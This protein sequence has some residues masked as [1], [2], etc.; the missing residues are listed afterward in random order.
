MVR[1]FSPW[2]WRLFRI[3]EVIQKFAGGLLVV[4]LELFALWRPT[5]NARGP[6]ECLSMIRRLALSGSGRF[7]DVSAVELGKF[8]TRRCG[9]VRYS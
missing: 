1:I 3:L 4:S 9:L 6:I 8:S 2:V 5:V 7:D